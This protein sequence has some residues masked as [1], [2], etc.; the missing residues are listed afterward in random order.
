[1]SWLYGYVITGLLCM[2]GGFILGY[3]VFG[4]SGLITTTDEYTRQQRDQRHNP[5]TRREP[6]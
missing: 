4:D 3:I 5:D 2:I 1:V 6:R